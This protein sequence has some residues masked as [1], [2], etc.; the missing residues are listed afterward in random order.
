MLRCNASMAYGQFHECGR[1]KAYERLVEDTRE[2]RIGQVSQ[3]GF[4]GMTLSVGRSG[5][6]S[7]Q[8][9]YEKSQY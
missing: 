6:V 9:G 8:S 2:E 1:Y 5:G 4:T 3:R 7:R